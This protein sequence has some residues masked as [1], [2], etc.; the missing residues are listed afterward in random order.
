MD[1]AFDVRRRL[2]G[3]SSPAN[4]TGNRAAHDHA[5]SGDGAGH[6]TLL[7][8]D[9]LGAADVTLNLA[10]DLQRSLADDLETL[11]DDG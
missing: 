9:D 7:A 11:A 8:D 1:I 3:Y 5:R 4:D 10:I 6:A 2:Q